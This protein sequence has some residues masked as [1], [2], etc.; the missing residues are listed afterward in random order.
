MTFMEVVDLQTA[1][2]TVVLVGVVARVYFGHVLFAPKWTVAWNAAR[3][4]VVPV[5]QH[6]IYKHLPFD[7]AIENKAVK[8]EYVGVTPL[9][10]KELAKAVDDQRDVEIPLL[11]G[12]KTD[13]EHR[14]ETGTFVW[15]HGSKPG[16]LPRWLKRQQVHVTTFEDEDGQTVI[17]A[18]NEANSYRPDQWKDHLTKGPTF[19][20]EEGIRRVENALEDA[21]VEYTADAS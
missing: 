12:L 10:P 5:L 3:R 19:S 7:I 13:W 1:A 4:A 2:V 14:P 15:Y 18:H 9:S 11:A 16:G 17:T 20:E 8:D 6:I 21:G